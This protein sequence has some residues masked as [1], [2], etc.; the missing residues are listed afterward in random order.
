[1]KYTQIQETPFVLVEDEDN[2]VCFAAVGHYR[3]TAL[4]ELKDENMKKIIEKL[5]KPTWNNI[6]PVIEVLVNRVLTNKK[7]KNG[8]NTQNH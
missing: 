2:E 7:Q 6:I 1:M 3:V 8:R 4:Q 5:E